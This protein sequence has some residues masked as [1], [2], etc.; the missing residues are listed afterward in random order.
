MIFDQQMWALDVFSLQKTSCCLN[1]S[2]IVNHG[3][4]STQRNSCSAESEHLEM[5]HD[6]SG[7]IC[8]LLSE[9]T[10]CWKEA[11]SN[12]GVCCPSINQRPYVSYTYFC[13]EK[14]WENV[15]S[16]KFKLTWCLYM[17]HML[18]ETSSQGHGQAFPSWNCKARPI[19]SYSTF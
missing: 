14:S 3:W 9:L 5:T 1:S 18:H 11:R 16:D 6:L 12:T 10:R 19:Y 15:F 2:V 13:R 4:L 8:S 7:L 17:R